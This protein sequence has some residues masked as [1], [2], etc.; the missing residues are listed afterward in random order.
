MM[1]ALLFDSRWIL[2]VGSEGW[3]GQ[4]LCLRFDLRYR[5][6]MI[7][8]AYLKYI[9]MHFPNLI[10]FNEVLQFFSCSC[11]TFLLST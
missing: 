10:D 9:Y 2:G 8:K 11:N 6:C 4:W 5:G 7:Y 1:A 3:G